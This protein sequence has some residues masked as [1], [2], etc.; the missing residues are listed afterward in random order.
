MTFDGNNNILLI[1]VQDN[2]SHLGVKYLHYTLLEKGFKSKLLFIPYFNASNKTLSDSLKAYV[3][4]I[5]PLYIGLSLTSLE[6]HRSRDLALFLKKVFPDIPIICGGIHPTVDP[7]SCL[8]FADYVMVGECEYSLID[9]TEALI[10]GT[11]V[12]EVSNLCYMENGK[13]KKNPLAPAIK[14]LDSLP[15]FDH[16]PKLSLIQRKDGTVCTIDRNIYHKEGRFRGRM[17]EMLSS[18]G[19]GFSCSYCTNSYLNKLYPTNKKVRRR[20]IQNI[21]K[22]LEKV[23]HNDPEIKQVVFHDSSFLIGKRDYFKEFCKEYKE[24]IGIPFI[25]STTPT[26]I[27]MEKL[28]LLKDAGVSWVTMAL[29]TGS[30]LVNKDIYKRYSFKKDYFNAVE[31]INKA[32]LPVKSDVI[33]DNP[34]EMEADTIE[35]IETIM[36]T[37]KPCLFEIFSLTLLPGTELFERAKIECPDMMEDCRGKNFMKFKQSYLNILTVLAVYLPK[38]IMKILLKLYKANYNGSVIFKVALYLSKGLSNVYY[39]PKNL[40]Y[41]LKLTRG[42]SYIDTFR[43]MPL[44]V[45]D[46]FTY[47]NL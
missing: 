21:I 33:L 10:N 11:D 34:F 7:E 8:S 43:I 20:S 15:I 42:D 39:K 22:E 25:V 31:L 3:S 5:K 9:F 28:M 46:Y 18:R 44:Y 37:P 30:D 38:S 45:K 4:E 13:M 47:R 32:R 12:K 16:I 26:S 2:L 19:C 27:D 6:Y 40:F 41:W 24:K 35:T 23:K 14:D 36:E 17:Y 1:P 29:Q